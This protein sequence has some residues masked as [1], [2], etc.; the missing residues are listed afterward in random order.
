MAGRMPGTEMVSLINHFLP[1]FFFLI[2]FWLHCVFIV[3]TGFLWWWAGA[4]LPCCV[5]ASHFS[6]VSCCWAQTLGCEGFRSRRLWALVQGHSSCESQASLARGVWDPP[7]PGVEPTSPALAGGFLPTAPPGKSLIL[8]LLVIYFLWRSGI[9]WMYGWLSWDCFKRNTSKPLTI[10]QAQKVTW[11]QCSELLRA[12]LEAV[13]HDRQMQSRMLQGAVQ[14]AAMNH[15]DHQRLTLLSGAQGTTVSQPGW[16]LPASPHD[17]CSGDQ[18]LATS[19]RTPSPPSLQDSG[20][21]MLKKRVLGTRCH[22]PFLFRF[23]LFWNEN[24]VCR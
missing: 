22:S 8:S 5:W 16:G 14:E 1:F 6:G 12:C 23:L 9:R 13:P 2:Y 4:S 15:A 20:F 17:S 3:C 7:G 10:S 18:H 11:E 21:I 24:R 19:T